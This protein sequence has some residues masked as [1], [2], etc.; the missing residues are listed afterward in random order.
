[1]N[2]YLCRLL[3]S[4]FIHHHN[5]D[6][7]LLFRAR[8]HFFGPRWVTELRVDLGKDLAL[9]MKEGFSFVVHVSQS[10]RDGGNT[11][12]CCCEREWRWGSWDWR[13]QQGCTVRTTKPRSHCYRA[14]GEPGHLCCYLCSA[15]SWCSSGANCIT[16]SDINFVFNL[17]SSFNKHR[18]HK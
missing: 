16:D 1:M 7:T 9:Q 13:R 18:G 6:I 8:S 11:V 10:V 5:H 12:F 3:C 4:V 17:Y 15:Q 2:V 14:N